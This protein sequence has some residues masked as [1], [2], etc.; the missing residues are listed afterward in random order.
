MDRDLVIFGAGGVAREI[1]G[2]AARIGYRIVA[3]VDDPAADRSLRG[4]PVI[5]TDELAAQVPAGTAF[6][7]AVG[8]PR[9]RRRLAGEAQAAGL[10]PAPALVHP[11]AD[12]DAAHV[13]LGE[14]TVVSA[15]VTLTADIVVADHVQINPQCTIGHDARLGA[16]CTLAPGARISGWVDVEPGAF[17]GAGAVTI[18]GRRDGP[19]RIGADAVV[20][21]GAVVIRDVAPGTT[22][23]GV[24][25][26]ALHP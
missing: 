5:R 21:A 1:D 24:P 20:G 14:G 17:I 18:D 23:A 9:L 12:L 16:F 13:T 25:A 22:V 10:R 2:W 7:A 6:L 19:L 26:R 4:R 15:G 8:D 3:F 11:T